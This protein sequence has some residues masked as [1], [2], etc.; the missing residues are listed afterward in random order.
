MVHR[1]EDRHKIRDY[2]YSDATIYLTRKR[3]KF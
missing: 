1:K 3:D 2:L